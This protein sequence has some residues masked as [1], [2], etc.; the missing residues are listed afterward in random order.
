M[1][2]LTE[3]PWKS[4][5]FLCPFPAHPTAREPQHVDFTLWSEVGSQTED[6]QERFDP[7]MQGESPSLGWQH[8]EGR[9]SNMAAVSLHYAWVNT[10]WDLLSSEARDMAFGIENLYEELMSWWYCY[11]MQ[12]TWQRYSTS[13]QYTPGSSPYSLLVKQLVY[14]AMQKA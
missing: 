4:C 7:V 5:V 13:S 12:Y 14:G 6:A 3:S 11:A 1:K 9:H 8:S 10:L 2:V